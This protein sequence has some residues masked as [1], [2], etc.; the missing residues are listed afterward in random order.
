MKKRSG[1]TQQQ[2]SSSRRDLPVTARNKTT[3]TVCV[4]ILALVAASTTAFVRPVE[5]NCD[6]NLF[7]LAGPRRAATSSVAD[8]L[9]QYARGAQPNREQGKV[10]HPLANFRWPMVYGKYSNNTEHDTPYK[11]FNH[12]VTDYDDENLR[13]EILQAI[14]TDYDIADV[15]GVIFGGEEFEQVGIHA[16]EGYDA[17][18]AVRDAVDVTGA[19]D[20]CVTVIINY[21]V[22]RFQHWVS[23]YSDTMRDSSMPYNEHMCVEE[24]MTTRV[25]ELGRSMNAMYLAETYLAEGWNVKM[26]DMGGVDRDG[27]DVAHSVACDVMGGK[28]DDNGWVK[29]HDEV[30]SN[31]ALE[32]DFDHLSEKE[33]EASEKLFRYRDCAFQE[34]LAGNPAFSIVRR[35]SIWED[36]KHDEDHEWIYQTFRDPDEGTRLMYDGLLSQIDCT[37]FGGAKSAVHETNSEVLETA[38][39]NDFLHG[40]YQKQSGIKATPTTTT[41]DI[42][43][44]TTTTTKDVDTTTITKDIEETIS[45]RFNPATVVVVLL[46]VLVIGFLVVKMR[47][48]SE[49]S[50]SSRIEMRGRRRRRRSTTTRRDNNGFTDEPDSDDESDDDDDDDDD[51]DKGDFV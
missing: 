36:C 5:A 6:T 43:T 11:R 10:Y 20:E 7:V 18:R 29:N 49:H 23:L 24:S 33:Q 17:I 21:R 1:D 35:D 39:I 37:S 48:K 25:E 32:Y 41:K 42:D 31:A 4:W 47:K 27:T 30:F 40:T 45:S 22:P 46:L 28:C 12:L 9:Y 26:I 50:N 8:F 2:R 19:K 38:K 13:N 15:W 16:K 44:T 3:T 51:D 14:K 34:S